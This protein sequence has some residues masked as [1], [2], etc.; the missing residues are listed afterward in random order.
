M[1]TNNSNNPQESKEQKCHQITVN[2]KLQLAVA[3]TLALMMVDISWSTKLQQQYTDKWTEFS[4]SMKELWSKA[5]DKMLMWLEKVVDALGPTSAYAGGNPEKDEFLDW[6]LSKSKK[7]RNDSAKQLKE[8]QQKR[9]HI[10]KVDTGIDYAGKIIHKK[11]PLDKN[12]KKQWN[13]KYR[14]EI[15]NNMFVYE[16]DI[17]MKF[18]EMIRLVDEILMYVK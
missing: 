7:Q 3:A 16:Q 9:I 12:T 2:E 4:Q 5:V 18:R 15:L 8:V 6:E 11:V 1:P 10:E 17:Q 13:E 14:S